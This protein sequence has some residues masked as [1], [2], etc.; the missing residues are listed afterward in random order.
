M[1]YN[2][3]ISA[4]ARS[5]QWQRVMNLFQSMHEA[6]VLPDSIT[7]NAVISSCEKG[8]QW[9]LRKLLSA[10]P[11]DGGDT[12]GCEGLKTVL[13]WGKSVDISTSMCIYILYI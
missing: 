7:S 8:G 12:K 6:E 5:A 3:T 9:N 10:I 13:E 11:K 2:A 4:C 1:S